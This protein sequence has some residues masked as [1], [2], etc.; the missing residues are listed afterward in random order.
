MSAQVAV[1][2]HGRWMPGE[3]TAPG[4]V[5]P[6]LIEAIRLDLTGRN[7]ACWWPSRGLRHGELL[8]AIA[9]AG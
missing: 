7:L 5:E 8:L 2:Q 9:N 1:A 3:I 4:G 6:P